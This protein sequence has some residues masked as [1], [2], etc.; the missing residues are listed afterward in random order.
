[1]VLTRDKYRIEW[2]GSIEILYL[3]YVYSKQPIFGLTREWLRELSLS[4]LECGVQ[5]KLRVSSSDWWD[6]L[7]PL[8]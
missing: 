8:A 3:S 1:M 5:D 2:K 7:L 6:V 4:R